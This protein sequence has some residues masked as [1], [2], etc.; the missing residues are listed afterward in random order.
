M[1]L[2]GPRPFG[3]DTVFDLE[4]DLSRRTALIASSLADCRLAGL[5][6]CRRV[7]T[8]LPSSCG[9]TARLPRPRATAIKR[10]TP[11]KR[12]DLYCLLTPHSDGGRDVAFV[13]DE[14][15][16]G[17]WPWP[18]RFGTL[19]VDSKNH[20][21]KNPIRLL[22]EHNGTEYVFHVPF[23]YFE[24]ADR[25]AADARWEASRESELPNQNDSA[26]WKYQVV[27]SQED[28]DPRLL[29]GRRH[30]QF[31]AARVV[32]DR[33][34]ES[35]RGKAERRIVI[36]RGEVHLLKMELDSVTPV[37]RGS[38]ARIRRPFDGLLDCSSN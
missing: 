36:G 7:V 37:G 8:V 33:K 25:L 6:R 14:H 16:G 30:E 20:A 18:A 3:E 19:A 35:A 22:H 24:F 13:V 12:F 1:R 21:N 27:A 29:A 28:R 38:P 26:P 5:L 10:P 11:A 9:T 17:S 31:R 4:A 15:G 34:Q 2:V 23:P 32:V